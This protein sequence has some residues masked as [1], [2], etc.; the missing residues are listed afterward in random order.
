MFNAWDLSEDPHRVTQNA[1]ECEGELWK[2]RTI[3]GTRRLDDHLL[4]RA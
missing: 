2:R 4:D 1:A 3:D